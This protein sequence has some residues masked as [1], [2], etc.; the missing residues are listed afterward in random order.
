MTDLRPTLNNTSYSSKSYRFKKKSQ[1]KAL[2]SLYN[3]KSICAVDGTRQ[4]EKLICLF[5][6][7]LPAVPVSST[8]SLPSPEGFWDDYNGDL[9]WN[10]P[11]NRD[12]DTLP[13]GGV[14]ATINDTSAEVNR[15]LVEC[16]TLRRLQFCELRKFLA[17]LYTDKISINTLNGELAKWN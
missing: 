4:R 5:S 13:A 17:I 16:N 15:R 12:G 2:N 7:V 11:N 14:G 6:L 8:S 9:L 3:K 1:E 10:N